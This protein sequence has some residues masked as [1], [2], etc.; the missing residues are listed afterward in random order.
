MTAK[1]AAQSTPN[2]TPN[3]P[4][5]QD[6]GAAWRA[7]AAS[8]AQWYLD[9]LVVR[10]DR[11]GYHK[12]Q[13]R[14]TSDEVLTLEVIVAHVHA[15][16][17]SDI[18]GGLMVVERDGVCYGKETAIDIDAHGTT[19]E[20]A[21]ANA[22]AA[23]AWYD[24]LVAL[25]YDPLLT[26][27]CPGS[28]HLR[29]IHQQLQESRKLQALG[30][31]LVADWAA[32]GVCPGA[33]GA[34][35][36]VYPKQYKLRG[37]RCGNWLRWPGRHHK[38]DAW[39]KV[40]DGAQWLEGAAAIEHMLGLRTAESLFV[41][42]D[43]DLYLHASKPKRARPVSYDDYVWSPDASPVARV[44]GALLAMRE[45]TDAALLT[46]EPPERAVAVYLSRC[47]TERICY[48]IAYPVATID[49]NYTSATSYGGDGVIPPPGY[50]W[51][52]PAAPDKIAVVDRILDAIPAPA[53]EPGWAGKAG[54]VA[55]P[56]T[57]QTGT[58]TWTVQ[59]PQ[60]VRSRGRGQVDF[61]HAAQT[62]DLATYL[63]LG[64]NGGKI[65]CPAHNDTR[66]S[67]S[68]YHAHGRW[69]YRCW[70]CGISGDSIAYL[71]HT[72]S[73]SRYEAAYRI[74]A[75]GAR[76]PKVEGNLVARPPAYANPAWQFAIS[77]IVAHAHTELG[78][79]AGREARTYLHSRGLTD[80]TIDIN[81][82]GWVRKTIVFDDIDDWPQGLIIPRGVVI[83]WLLPGRDHADRYDPNTDDPPV[84]AGFNVRLL[85]NPNLADPPLRRNG[86]PAPKYIS[87]QGSTRIY[88]Y[89]R[90]TLGLP[91]APLLVVE[92][93]FD[94]L[95]ATQ[96]LGR[97]FN[98]VTWC[99]AA[100]TP[101]GVHVP[102]EFKTVP[103]CLLFDADPAGVAAAAKWLEAY[104]TARILR[105]P[106][107]AGDF[108]ELYKSPQSLHQ[109]LVQLGV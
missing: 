24:T 84:Y 94:A 65:I 16:R 54:K 28:Y 66:P 61:D 56:V 33:G 91:T 1:P 69:H 17:R 78:T 38:R 50:K 52:P 43:I 14:A 63:G 60:H 97:R 12:A 37:K 2:D 99:S 57:V 100:S 9:N 19:P 25:G 108:T 42:P 103:W 46:C 90:S 76:L 92:G 15:A 35:P 77:E 85:G 49:P 89:P 93:E 7:N 96:C 53:Y 106:H 71:A 109:W 83:P 5:D 82:L 75:R 32:R 72:L 22:V 44:F 73:V 98:V 105:L 27:E 34:G 68:I 88:P 39:T 104:P 36:E 80:A 47:K 48:L 70:A 102:D 45:V 62:F 6:P 64:A 29:A 67:M 79:V 41:P 51:V 55:R 81:R 101:A 86:D 20:Q 18:I 31:W 21:A 58:P 3:T 4:H 10:V 23:I 30:R 40:W 87:A 26:S 95:L 59:L 107:G 13:S 11:Y 74:L 8:I